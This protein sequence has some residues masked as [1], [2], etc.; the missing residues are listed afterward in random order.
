MARCHNYS[1]QE[2]EVEK[3]KKRATKKF[4]FNLITFVR[5]EKII[6]GVFFLGYGGLVCSPQAHCELGDEGRGAGWLA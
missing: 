5:S 1:P 4:E 3:V 2:A 6:L